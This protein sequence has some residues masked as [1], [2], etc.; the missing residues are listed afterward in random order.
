MSNER[1]PR[2]VCSTTIGTRELWARPICISVLLSFE[3]AAAGARAPGGRAKLQ[4][5]GC[6]R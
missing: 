1:S 5:L 6:I 2:D 3:P 4:L